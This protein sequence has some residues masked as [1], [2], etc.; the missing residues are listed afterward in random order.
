MNSAAMQT[1]TTVGQSASEM[2]LALRDA[3]ARLA[4][5]TS[6]AEL[7]R[8][9]PK[10]FQRP[11]AELAGLLDALARD[12]VLATV[13]NAKT[14]RY[15][16]A[17]KKPAAAAQDD[18]AQVLAAVGKLAALQPEGALLSVRD[19]RATMTLPKARFD[20]AV[21]RLAKAEEVV[22]H[23]HDYPASLTEVERA[24]LVKDA[25]GTH[26]VGIAPRRS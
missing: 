26:Y 15:T 8:A 12:G 3:L 20:A 25:Q 24:A 1:G 22:I 4:K 19:L 16:L 11:V 13:G 5:P 2:R 17:Q 9:L 21:L 18:D 7:R 14:S 10:P 6:A 23:F